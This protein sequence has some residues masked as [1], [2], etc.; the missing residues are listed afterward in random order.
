MEPNSAGQVYSYTFHNVTADHTIKAVFEPYPARIAG[1]TPVYYLT[2][3]A[4][5]DAAP[6]GATIQT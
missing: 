4:A 6:D 3:Q 5:Y 2:L 1:T